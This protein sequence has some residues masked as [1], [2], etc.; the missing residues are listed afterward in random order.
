MEEGTPV[1][2][3][4][5]LRRID[6]VHIGRPA[7]IPIF[8]PILA[9]LPES[10]PAVARCRDTTALS[11]E[12][13]RRRRCEVQLSALNEDLVDSRENVPDRFVAVSGRTC[14]VIRQEHAL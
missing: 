14:G 12:I 2:M 8:E 10:T 1:V 13:F 7:E 11:S 4:R 3:H 9:R 6:E 5:H